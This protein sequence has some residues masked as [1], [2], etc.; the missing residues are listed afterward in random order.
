MGEL[1]GAGGR[2]SLSKLKGFIHAEGVVHKNECSAISVKA[3]SDPE[4]P[5][6]ADITKVKLG[7]QELMPSEFVGFFTID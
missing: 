7:V 4:N 1:T 6:V 5:K 2:M 3:S